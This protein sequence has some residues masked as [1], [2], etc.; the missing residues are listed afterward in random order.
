MTRL[1]PKTCCHRQQNLRNLCC[2]NLGVRRSSRQS[3]EKRPGARFS[4]PNAARAA[5]APLWQQRK[6]AADLLAVAS[7]IFLVPDSCWKP[8]ASAFATFSI[9]PAV[10]GILAGVQRGNDSRDQPGIKPAFPVCSLA[11]LFLRRELHLRRRRAA[12]RTPRA[13]AFHRSIAA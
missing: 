8:I 12:G 5:R 3:F 13:G 10:A 1:R 4:C 7:Q 2:G 11:A 9:L 6:R